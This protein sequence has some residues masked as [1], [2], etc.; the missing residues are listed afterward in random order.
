[1]ATRY[2][3]KDVRMAFEGA[4]KA[5]KTAGL[6]S[7]DWV[8]QEGSAPN[9]VAYRIFRKRR[10]ESG[11]TDLGFTNGNGFL[12]M[13]ARQAYDA[14]HHYMGAWWA[15]AEARGRGDDA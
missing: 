11:L 5:A 10:G 3:V 9:G 15:V 1:M 2:T 6:D 12:G 14:L 8:L 13:T 7:S 4:C